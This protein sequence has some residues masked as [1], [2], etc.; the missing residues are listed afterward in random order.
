MA[1]VSF[2]ALRTRL[3]SVF[4]LVLVAGTTHRECTNIAG[5]EELAF[6]Q[7]HPH[8]VPTN[9]ADCSIHKRPHS[10]CL[11]LLQINIP[12]KKH[13]TEN[14]TKKN[15]VSAQLQTTLENK[16]FRTKTKKKKKAKTSCRSSSMA[17]AYRS[18]MATLR[19]DADKLLV[20]LPCIGLHA[21]Q[22]R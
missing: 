16:I 14:A 13:P 20:S 6:R 4:P 10:C 3:C 18:C 15:R 12:H 21:E 2:P 11:G 5:H 8:I 9:L 22:Q 17:A 1:D 19:S 7:T